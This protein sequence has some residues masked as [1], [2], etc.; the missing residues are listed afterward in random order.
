MLTA[1]DFNDKPILETNKIDNETVPGCLATEME[2]L[3]TPAAKVIPDFHL[4]GRE[5]LP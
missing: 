3:I 5:Y 1:I 2:S 4:L